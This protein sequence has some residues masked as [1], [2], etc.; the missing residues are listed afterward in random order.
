MSP[1]FELARTWLTGQIP[2][3]RDISPGISVKGTAFAQLLE[4]AKFGDV[5]ARR[6]DFTGVVEL[7]RDL[8]VAF[9]ARYRLY[10]DACS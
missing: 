9:D 2:Q 10:N 1:A 7:N 8:G 4:A 6:L 3:T 5:E